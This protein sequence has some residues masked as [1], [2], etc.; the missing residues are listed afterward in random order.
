VVEQVQDGTEAEVVLG[1]IEILT[2]QNHQ[3]VVEVLKVL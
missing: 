1:V 2:L 3:V